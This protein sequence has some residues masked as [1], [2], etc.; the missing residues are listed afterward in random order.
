MRRGTS[1]NWFQVLVQQGVERCDEKT[2]ETKSDD[3]DDDELR[4]LDCN[5]ECGSAA[6]HPA[7]RL[8]AAFTTPK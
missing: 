6:I 1:G 4:K 3:D 2:K 7:D 5:Q 8:N